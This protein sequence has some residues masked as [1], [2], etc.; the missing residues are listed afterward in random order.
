MVNVVSFVQALHCQLEQYF[1]YI[2]SSYLGK[3]LDYRFRFLW[4]LVHCDNIDDLGMGWH[5]G[6]VFEWSGQ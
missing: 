2:E 5:F 3:F 6:S 1:S 4:F